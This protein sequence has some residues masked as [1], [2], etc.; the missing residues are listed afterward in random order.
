MFVEWIYYCYKY[1]D[2]VG[3]YIS[4]RHFCS[5]FKGWQG[6]RSRWVMNPSPLNVYNDEE[7]KQKYPG[8][9]ETGSVTI[10]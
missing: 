9:L 6:T 4:L 3:F 8:L 7:I 2:K 10:L 1:E 5:N